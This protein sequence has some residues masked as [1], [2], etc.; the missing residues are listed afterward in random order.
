MMN[1]NGATINKH[2]INNSSNSSSSSSVSRDNNEYY[3]NH[4]NNNHF[5][6]SVNPNESMYKE[7]YLKKYSYDIDYYNNNNNN[8][9]NETNNNDDNYQNYY[10]YNRSQEMRP[11]ST[12][13]HHIGGPP[14][15][16]SSSSSTSTN[17]W[18]NKCVNLEQIIR[19]FRTNDYS[20]FDNETKLLVNTIRD[21][22]ID[23]SPIDVNVVKR[24]DSDEN[25]MKNY[26]RLVR[27]SGGIAVPQN[28]FVDS[29]VHT[30]LPSY[31]QKFYN[32]GNL[33][34]QESSL[35]EAA[36]QLGLAV[37][38]QVA[39]AV[40]NSM[41]IPL[42]F[43]QQL[44]NNYITLLLKQAQ[45]PA[46]IQNSVQSRRYNQLNN[47]NDL[48]NM[49]IDNIFAGGNDYYY[50][51]LNDKNRAR[52][53]SLKENLTYLGALSE[54]TNIFEFI[55][56]LA[57]RKGKQPGLF[58]EAYNIA[59]SS[60]NTTSSSRFKIAQSGTSKN[61]SVHDTYRRSLTEMAFQNE[62]LRR[63]IFQ[64]LSYKQNKQTV[65]QQ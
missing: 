37:Q 41:P 64:Q 14:N 42:P 40:T 22:C 62:A 5:D 59:N 48:I 11:V 29:F 6:S 17:M 16:S 23:T 3:T 47:I 24:F 43:N 19:Y 15:Y 30:V 57:T 35:A 8:N 49:V 4:Y 54:T 46:N 32:R 63:F 33:N 38:Y 55:A 12:I 61:D 50:Y 13:Q 44:T 9:N 60:S 18:T 2:Q 51:V 21:I 28:I 52:I 1:N 36:R 7:S 10:R 20:G 31:A 65:G 34:L 25:L 45:I 53:I 58:R 26:E 39:Q 27:E 56:E